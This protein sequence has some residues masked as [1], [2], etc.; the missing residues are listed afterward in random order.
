MTTRHIYGSHGDFE[1]D[2]N[3]LPIG[4]VPDAYKKYIRF[5]LK[6]Y[7][8]W[9]AKNGNPPKLENIDIMSIGLWFSKDGI[10]TYD[11]PDEEWRKIEVGGWNT[12]NLN[13]GTKEA[14]G[15]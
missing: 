2:E 15:L 12:L 3:G 6:E 5:D 11:P 10:E 14:L 4:E 7:N 9:C 1:I 8:E 13:E